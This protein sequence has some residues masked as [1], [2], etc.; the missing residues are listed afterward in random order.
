MP[1]RAIPR[2]FCTN[3]SWLGCS[4][5]RGIS[6]ERFG[7]AKRPLLHWTRSA[8]NFAPDIP[9]STLTDTEPAQTE[10]GNALLCGLS[11]SVQGFPALPG[12]RREIEKVRAVT[13]DAEVLLDRK[14]TTD[15]LRSVF[16]DRGCSLALM[17]THGVFRG[18]AR[19]TFLVTYDGRLYMN[20]LEELIRLGKYREKQ[21]DILFLSACQTA[22]GDERAALGLGGLA[23]RTGVR[24]A[25][26]TLWPVDDRATSEIVT[27]FCVNLK[28]GSSKAEAL[29]NARKKLMDTPGYSHPA[30]WAPFLLIGSRL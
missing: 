5:S 3:G 4:K 29:Q 13:G 9:G 15:N 16:R 11:E 1:R 2:S 27:R 23:V 26:A 7:P 6:G 24:S 21:V 14:F 28:A 25:I 17:A 22:L 10:P 12:V 8:W 20:Q 18:S 19:E 30:Y